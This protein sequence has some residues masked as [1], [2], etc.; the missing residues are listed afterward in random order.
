MGKREAFIAR[1][2]GF[3]SRA[4]ICPGG[5][6]TIGSGLTNRCAVARDWWIARYGR[7]IK[8]GD[9]ITRDENTMLLKRALDDEYAPPVAPALGRDAPTHAYDAGCSVSYNCGPRALNWQWARIY[10]S[11]D[12][13]KAAARL[14]KTAVTS[15]GRRL[16]GLVRRRKEEADLMLH[17]HAASKRAARVDPAFDEPIKEMQRLLKKI[18][19]NPG[20]IDGWPGP[21]TGAAVR[22]LQRAHG[23]VVD[24]LIGPATRAKIL[25]LANLRRETTGATAAGGGTAGAGAVADPGADAAVVSQMADWAMYGGLIVLIAGLGYL[26][27]FYR[28]EIA[29]WIRRP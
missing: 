15:R 9:T 24:G 14:E 25:R 8:I 5:V 1:H 6:V 7:K 20:A 19:Y 27:Y 21:E 11:G 26:A 13:R 16:A 4:Y 29:H 17:G 10:R 3:S 12:R 22:K 28:G 18:G 23:L 2:E